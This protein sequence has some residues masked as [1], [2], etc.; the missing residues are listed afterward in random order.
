MPIALPKRIPVATLPAGSVLWPV[1]RTAHGPLWFGPR[2][3][4]PPLGRFD[5]PEG[6]FGVCYFGE[7]LGA[8]VLETLVRGSRRLLDRAELE[9]RV[10]TTFRTTMP[11]RF[12]QLEGPGLA[13]IGIG[14]GAEQA[15]AAD[16]RDCQRMILELFQHHPELDG[17][18][19]RSR[20]DTSLRC[21][22][23]F[24]R[25]ADKVGAPGPHAWLG[26]GAVI[27]P[28][29]DRYALAVV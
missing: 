26:D 29:L 16:Y 9:A 10:A 18:Q 27:G 6:E 15:H 3:G 4:G 22:A 7:A 23:V 19:Y 11:M 1:H 13:R 24:D 21:W 12:L 28:V 20:W 2:P 8:A 5:A 14:I 17:V 25:A